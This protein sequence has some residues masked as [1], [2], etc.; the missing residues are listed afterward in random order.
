MTGVKFT[1]NR[2]D[3]G[4]VVWLTAELGWSEAATQAAIFADDDAEAAR[5]EVAAACHRNDIVAAYEAA[6]DGRADRSMRE[7]IRAGRGPTITH[8]TDDGPQSA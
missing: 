8:P 7:H 4:V 3:D 2:L 5:S 1:A 6:V